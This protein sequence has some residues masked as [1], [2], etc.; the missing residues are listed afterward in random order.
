MTVKAKKCKGCKALPKSHNGSGECLTGRSFVT[1][2]NQIVPLGP[3]CPHKTITV[4]AFNY[5]ILQLK[6]VN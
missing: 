4:E 1:C 3:S 6:N 5:K 2:D